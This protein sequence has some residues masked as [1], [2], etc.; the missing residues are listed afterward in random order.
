MMRQEQRS[1]I[2]LVPGMTLMVSPIVLENGV[3]STRM[4][5]DGWAY[6]TDDHSWSV[7]MGGTLLVTQNGVQWL[8]E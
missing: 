2:E 7:Q 5:L 8:T 3:A 1:E 6:T 4:W